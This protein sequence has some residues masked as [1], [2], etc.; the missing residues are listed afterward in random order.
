MASNEK[1][2]KENQDESVKSEF[3][4]RFKANP[5]V[6]IGTI[7]I[8]IIVVIA[9]VLVP[10]IVPNSQGDGIDLTFGS[11]NKIPISYVQGN[12][13]WQ[14]QRNLAQQYQSNLDESNYQFVLYQIWRQAFE[15]AAVQ[16]AVLSEMKQAGYTAPEDV[17]NREVAQLPQFQENGRFSAAKYR[18]MDN[19]S[20]MSLWRQVQDSIAAAYYISD[21][22]GLKSSSQETAFISSMASPQRRFEY[23]VF[24][25][26]SYPDSE[27][28]A[29]VQTNPRL[30]RV[31]H[32][33][34][35]TVNSGE[36]EARQILAS[37]QEGITTFEDA[38]KTSSQDGFAES[39]G[40]MGIRIAYE[41]T[42]DI[43]D[44]SAREG[45][46]N[47]AK[48]SFSDVIQ[49]SE[50]SWVFFRAEEEPRQADTGD[51][52]LM[53]KIRSYIMAYERGRAE[54]WIIAEA[55]KFNADVREKGFDSALAD[56]VMEKK[57]FGP[58]P[59]NYGDT[60]IFASVTSS[61]A[62]ELSGAGTNENFW[63]TGFTTPLNS[64][65]EPM[66]MGDNVVVL[67]PLEETSQDPENAGFIE[68]YFS[69]WL[70]NASEQTINSH[71]LSSGKLD[72][73]FWD[74]FQT[75]WN[76]N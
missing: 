12:Y 37:I 5:F 69:Y 27:I 4:R 53:T 21:I 17:V 31:T 50:N 7:V 72:D 26:S 51:A 6:F 62:P 66:V 18:Q 64:P 57:S 9:F 56:H 52:A 13:F 28:A 11:Y 45:V 43:T 19:N 15:M 16:T 65:S 39:G 20:R 59:V 8:L 10:A 44:E 41:L 68:M 42:S 70:S 1:K 74:V 73:R 23:A 60:A 55:Q 22:T 61:D 25:M 40:D 71:F 29:Y 76:T 54:D 38:A 2:K 34:R 30:F 35:I 58:L 33:S 48:G 32:L 14:I 46:I 63:R 47:L 75:I 49:L 24:P 67:Y 3:V 36:R